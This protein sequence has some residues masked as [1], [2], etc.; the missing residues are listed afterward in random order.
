MGDK[1][2]AWNKEKNPNRPLDLSRP[3][4]LDLYDLQRKLQMGM[5]RGSDAILAEALLGRYSPE[6]DCD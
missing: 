6:G 5:L 2:Q 3:T 1:R 4:D